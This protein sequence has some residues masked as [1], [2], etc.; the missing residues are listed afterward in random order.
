[1]DTR[2]AIEHIAE[3]TGATWPELFRMMYE[4]FHK[5]PPPNDGAIELIARA[6]R[7][8]AQPFPGYVRA[9][10]YKLYG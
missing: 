4:W 5:E 7:D 1:M 8:H 9:Y 10:V 3:G 2:K 6:C